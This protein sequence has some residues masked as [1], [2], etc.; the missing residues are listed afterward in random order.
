MNPPFLC[1][2]VS[3]G[4]TELVAA[5]DIGD[6]RVLG[7]TRDDAAGEAFDK[8]G[9]ML[10]LPYPAGPAI[11]RLAAGGRPGAVSLPRAMMD[12]ETFDFSFSGL[13]TAAM[14]LIQ[15]YEQSGRP[16][17]KADIAAELQEAIVDVLV[18]KTMQA[19]RQE[20]MQTVLLAGGVAANGHLRLRMEEAC[21]RAG[22]QGQPDLA[23]CTDNAA[24]IA[25][26]AFFRLRRASTIRSPSMRS[27]ACAWRPPPLDAHAQGRP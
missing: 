18:G 23:Y 6:Y 26:A 20:G 22:L 10:G 24:M 12:G 13:K 7:R 19:A 16:L 2:T 25:C 27:R 21:A 14:Q 9:R 4:H 11:E 17:P 15:G 3:G 5:Y 8:V 1:L